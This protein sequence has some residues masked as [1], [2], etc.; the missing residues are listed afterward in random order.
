MDQGRSEI[1]QTAELLYL[2]LLG[3][4]EGKR[5]CRTGTGTEQARNMRK[6]VD[7][8]LVRH[9]IL[10][11]GMI[12][13]LAHGSVERRFSAEVVLRTVGDEMLADGRK[14]WGRLVALYAFAAEW[15]RHLVSTE[16]SCDLT[17]LAAAF[18]QFVNDRFGQW[19]MDN[20]G[21]VSIIACL[22]LIFVS[23]RVLRM[24]GNVKMI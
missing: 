24:A 8:L 7:R 22:F 11:R 2:D 13:R 21:W 9:E 15:A 19:I 14:N 18:A 5:L 4:L 10:F 20:G 6:L 1:A 23:N 3:H 16:Q 12:G 17:A